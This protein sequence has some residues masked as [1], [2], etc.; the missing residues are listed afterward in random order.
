LTNA[1]LSALKVGDSLD[2]CVLGSSTVS[3][4]GAGS[5]FPG[6]FDSAQ[7]SINGNVKTA[8]DLTHLTATARGICQPYTILATDTSVSV[9]AKI[10]HTAAGWVGENF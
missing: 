4:G 3:G 2:F 5:A 10:H 1:Q 7:F 8:I 6:S 9:K